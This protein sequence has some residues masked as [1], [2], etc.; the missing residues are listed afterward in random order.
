MEGP[1]QAGARYSG[2]AAPS[3]SPFGRGSWETPLRDA[4]ILDISV[5]TA[6]EDDAVVYAARDLAALMDGSQVGRE[7]LTHVAVSSDVGPVARV[8]GLTSGLSSG[9]AALDVG[10]PGGSGLAALGD[11]A[12][13]VTSG[14]EAVAAAVAIGGR[15]DE[16]V[17]HPPW[18]S[19]LDERWSQVTAEQSQSWA[20]QRAGLDRK[21]V[22]DQVKAR[23]A[24]WAKTGKPLARMGALDG[25][26]SAIGD[27]GVGTALLA[28]H[29]EIREHGWKTRARITSVVRIGVD[30]TLGLAAAGQAAEAALHRLQLRADEMSH[31]QVDARSA[32]TPALVGRALSLGPDRINAHGDSLCGGHAGGAG[33]MADL[34]RLLDALEAND[35]RFGMV[36]GIEPLGVA[37]AIVVDRQFY[38]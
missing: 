25:I 11:A 30:P 33:G 13:A 10:G 16:Q 31:V 9:I 1:A 15:P 36:V 22:L 34:V 38:I 27:S 5:R 24:V 20:L 14:F 29:R 21:T 28:G 8:V 37:T 4:Y 32:V 19:S 17:A 3:G 18:L 26:P 12:R 35:R 23:R 6:L 2:L 7:R